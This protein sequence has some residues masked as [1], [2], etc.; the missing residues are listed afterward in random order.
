MGGRVGAA[1]A[2]GTR[3]AAGAQNQGSG[4]AG[5]EPGRPAAGEGG[6]MGEQGGAG[7]NAGAAGG[8]MDA[9]GDASAGKGADVGAG[10]GGGGVAEGGQAGQSPGVCGV[11]A[12]SQPPSCSSAE[13]DPDGD[14]ECRV[15]MKASCCSAW[16]ACFGVDPRNA[17]GHGAAFGDEIGEMDCVT[18]C[19]YAH[20]DGSESDE[21]I[22]DTCSATC[23]AC[24]V[25]TITDTT[26]DLVACAYAE[27]QEV[28]YPRP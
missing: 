5:G 25:N 22:L 20:R 6:V 16:R 17:C 28:C 1:G 24:S 14:S 4:G 26:S 10:G 11:G 7:S 12:P 15:C 27:C 9:G 19:W 23:A 18:L 8:G 21:E 2:A 3:A 13:P